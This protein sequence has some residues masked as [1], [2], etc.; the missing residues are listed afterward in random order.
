MIKLYHTECNHWLPAA[1]SEFKQNDYN[2][3]L[4]SDTGDAV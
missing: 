1:E 3:C 4:V 2:N